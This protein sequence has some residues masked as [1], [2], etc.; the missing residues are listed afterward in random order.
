MTMLLPR[1]EINAAA[2]FGCIPSSP[3]LVSKM[4]SFGIT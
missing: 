2:G 1:D 3:K 4:L